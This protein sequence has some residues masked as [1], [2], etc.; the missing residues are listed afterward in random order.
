MGLY[1][2]R[3]KIVSLT[4]KRVFLNFVSIDMPTNFMQ[5]IA[6]FIL[7]QNNIWIFWIIP[8]RPALG[9]RRRES[10]IY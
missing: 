2:S 3:V 7:L 1:Y 10:K 4:I 5:N 8:Q 9:L 6:S